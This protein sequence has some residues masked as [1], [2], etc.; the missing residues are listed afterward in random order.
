MSDPTV[1]A[2]F[3]ALAEGYLE[4]WK[5]TTAAE[6]GKREMAYAQYKA[7]RDVEAQLKSWAYDAKVRDL[8]EKHE[9]A[10]ES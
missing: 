10:A 5:H 2:A 7:V 4:V 1:I 3:E 8:K 9:P 6:V